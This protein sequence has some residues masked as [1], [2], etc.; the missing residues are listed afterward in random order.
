MTGKGKGSSV[1]KLHM[2]GSAKE[3]S[4]DTSDLHGFVFIDSALLMITDSLAIVYCH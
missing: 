4:I 1:T 2:V 3:S